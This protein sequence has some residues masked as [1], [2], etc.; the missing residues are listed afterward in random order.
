MFST[1]V[2][3]AE[4]RVRRVRR[5]AGMVVGRVKY[6]VGVGRVGRWVVRGGVR[7]RGR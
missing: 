2:G 7:W 4:E 5:M 3:A 1:E 6:M